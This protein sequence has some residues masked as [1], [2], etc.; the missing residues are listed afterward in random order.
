MPFHEC[1]HFPISQSFV[2]I[3]QFFLFILY[4]RRILESGC[5]AI[6]P[7]D[8]CRV[9]TWQGYKRAECLQPTGAGHEALPLFLSRPCARSTLRNAAVVCLWLGTG[10]PLARP[11]V[12]YECV[13]QKYSTAIFPKSFFL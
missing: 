5:P 9:T 10:F 7:D 12:T 11:F 3:L 2:F 4:S 8:V 1:D 6:A 13:F